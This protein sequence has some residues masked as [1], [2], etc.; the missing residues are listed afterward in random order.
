V[1]FLIAI[2]THDRCERLVTVASTSAEALAKGRT[3]RP[4]A[5]RDAFRVVGRASDD[6][7]LIPHRGRPPHRDRHVVHASALAASVPNA[8]E[9]E[10]GYFGVAEI[11]K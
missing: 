5:P 1:I 7:L 4:S 2:R 6:V 8:R 10:A 3:A 11:Q 9:F